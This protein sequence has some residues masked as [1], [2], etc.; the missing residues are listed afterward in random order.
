MRPAL[1]ELRREPS[2][3]VAP[4]AI[5]TLIA[6]LLMFLG[7][8][9]DGLIRN[10][11]G[12]VNAI[13]A[14][15]IVFS[16]SSQGSFLRSRVEPDIRKEIEQDLDAVVGGLGVT[17]LGGRIPG[18]GPR[19]LANIAVWGYETPI[20][21]VPSPPGA[22]MGW[23]DER[24]QAD[25]V[26]IGDEILLGPSRTPV[27]IAGWVD[28]TAYNGQASLWVDV[29]TWRTVLNA[30]RPD[31]ALAE[32]VFQALAVTVPSTTAGETAA[33]AI[34]RVVDSGLLV[35]TVAEARDAIPG[36]TEQQQTFNQILGVTVLIA[37][38]VVALFFALLTVERASLYAVFKALGA[39]SRTIFGGL[40][41]QA[42]AVTMIATAIAAVAVVVIDAVIPPGSIPLFISPR[43]ILLSAVL[44]FIAAAAGCGFSLRRVLRVDPA[45]ALGGSS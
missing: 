22:G 38:V 21:G 24:L 13:T 5:L 6:V 2:R 33:D 18:N 25:G 4:T 12:A 14:D 30:N 41:T 35:L 16:D 23:G 11:T 40:I 28:N 44:L 27:T 7:G 9:L 39:G 3:F 43:R 31:A 36:V 19:D 1:K 15:V 34:V 20:D 10:S 42:I 29:E 32:G 45:T 17:L 37:L 8:L 26:E